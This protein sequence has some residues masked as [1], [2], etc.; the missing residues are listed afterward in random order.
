[1]TTNYTEEL[2]LN[3]DKTLFDII[4]D[5]LFDIFLII[6]SIIICFIKFGISLFL[7]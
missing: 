4:F 7:L 2:N 6:V 3:T 5:K 1:M